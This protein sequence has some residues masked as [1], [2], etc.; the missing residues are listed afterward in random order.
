[1]L[2]SILAIHLIYEDIHQI[3]VGGFL[4]KHV[5]NENKYFIDTNDT[6]KL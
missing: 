2:I 3:D 1:M 5:K 6:N 4:L